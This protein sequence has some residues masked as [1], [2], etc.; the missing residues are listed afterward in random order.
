MG[1]NKKLKKVVGNDNAARGEAEIQR[2][3]ED[4]AEGMWLH[5]L[6]QPGNGGSG[7]GIMQVEATGPPALS[8]L[9]DMGPQP[10]VVDPSAVGVV[11]G[12][13]AVVAQLTSEQEGAA[14]REEN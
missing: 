2:L 12:G 1:K 11:E 6:S 13:E 10:T 4:V 7:E 9:D 14:T 8:T 5:E 3:N